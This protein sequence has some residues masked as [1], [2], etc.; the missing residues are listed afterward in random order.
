[1]I[2]WDEIVD[3]DGPAVWRACWRLLGNRAD[4]DEAF[5]EAFVAAYELSKRQV[6][7]SP[8]AVLQH[9][10]TARSI[11][12]LRARQRHRKRHEAVD[13]ER[14]NEESAGDP[15]PRQH[16]EA[17]EL[18]GE[19]RQAL[20]ALPARQAE[21]FVLHAIEGWAYTEIAE[22]LGLTVDHVG[23]LIHRARAKLKVSLGHFARAKEPGAGDGPSGRP[24]RTTR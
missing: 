7:A 23:V 3:R 13:D 9:L 2:D 14:L 24:A 11:D 15:S 20:T 8:R 19:L 16:A 4:A 21:A 6:L 12:R 17:A 5:Q 10:A 22:R 18:R 1:M